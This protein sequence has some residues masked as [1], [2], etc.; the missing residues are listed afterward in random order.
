MRAYEASQSIGQP[1]AIVGYRGK[2]TG[3]I[4]AYERSWR[5]KSYWVAVKI[6][7]IQDVADVFPDGVIIYR[8]KYVRLIKAK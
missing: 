1:V 2:R 8:A 5:R 4:V 6:D 3:V 7:Q